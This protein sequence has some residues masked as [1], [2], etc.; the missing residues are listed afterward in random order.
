M[1]SPPSDKSLSPLAKRLANESLGESRQYR[2]S[3]PN[4]NSPLL[5]PYRGSSTVEHSAPI[6]IPRAAS[7]GFVPDTKKSVPDLLRDWKDS[8]IV[9]GHAQGGQEASLRRL[10]TLDEMNSQM[11]LESEL[12]PSLDIQYY[13]E[14]KALKGGDD[15]PAGHSLVFLYDSSQDPHQLHA[16]LRL[17]HMPIVMIPGLIRGYKLM[18]WCFEDPAA[19][20]DPNDKEKE[21]HGHLYEVESEESFMKLF[22]WNS[23]EYFT[24]QEMTVEVEPAPGAVEKEFVEARAFIWDWRKHGGRELVDGNWTLGE[25]ERLHKYKKFPEAVDGT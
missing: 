7:P 2:D 5:A 6:D 4:A 23:E 24:V 3:S 21:V 17:N 19:M 1:S 22:H 14:W 12:K 15:L 13:D 25:W 11:I 18:R 8:G 9:Q 10:T 16:I 20:P